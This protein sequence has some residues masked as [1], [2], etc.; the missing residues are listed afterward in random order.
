LAKIRLTDV[1]KKFGDFAAVNQI[2]LLAKDKEFIAL[3][4]PSGCGK[5]TTLR[6][7]YIPT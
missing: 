5:T 6:M 1:T 3:V 7:I 4:G 2:N